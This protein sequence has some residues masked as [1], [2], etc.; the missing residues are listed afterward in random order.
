MHLSVSE[1]STDP[2]HIKRAMVFTVEEVTWPYKVTYW[3]FSTGIPRTYWGRAALSREVD[4]C[5]YNQ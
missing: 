2:D 3:D 5:I 1:K 4:A